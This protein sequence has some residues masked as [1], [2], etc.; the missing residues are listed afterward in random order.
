MRYEGLIRKTILLLIF[1]YH[2]TYHKGQNQIRMV[3][4]II[5]YQHVYIYKL[6]KHKVKAMNNMNAS[7]VNMMVE[8][9]IKHVTFLFYLFADEVE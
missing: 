9:S 4:P 5:K 7:L 3:Y 1:N 2:K 6:C 8:I